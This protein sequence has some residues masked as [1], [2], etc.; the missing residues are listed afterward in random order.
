MDEHV[1]RAVTAG[2][3]LRGL[4]VLTTQEDGRR[5]FSDDRI[6]DRATELGRPLF[7]QDVD[8]LIEAQRRQKSGIPFSG[9]IYIHPLHATIGDCIRDLELIARVADPE[10]LRNRVEFLPL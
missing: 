10:D 5:G 4:D 7:S 3:R 2:L 8:L 1:H 9:V 6:L